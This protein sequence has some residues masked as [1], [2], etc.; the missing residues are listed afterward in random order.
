MR[1]AFDVS[2]LSHPPLGIGNYIRGSLGGLVEA[3]AGEHEIVAFAPTSIH[4]PARIRAAL[5]GIDVELRTWRLPFSHAV[6]TAWSAAGRPATERLLGAFD[7][8]HF[9]DWMFP[10][11]RSG[12]RATT[13]HDLVPLHHP[14]WTTSRTRSMHARKYENAARTCDVVF[15]NSAFTGRD[16]VETLGIDAERVHVARPA[17]KAVFRAD[18]DAADLGRPYVLTVATLEPRKNLQAL[19]EAHRLLESDLLLAIAGGEGW[20]E[21]PELDDPG[22][23]RLGFVTDA[24]L[25]RLYRGAAAAVY[26]SRFEGFGIPVIEAMACGC[27][28]V[29]S[30]HESLDEAAGDAAVRADPED[31]AAIAAAIGR[32]VGDRQRLAAAGLEHVQRSSWR[33]VGE[34]FLRGYEAAAR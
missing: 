4:G 20:G 7:V 21:Q 11:Q 34:I 13:I 24:E 12:V 27:P 16:V 28:V 23:R 9:S 8:L 31:P 3:A 26:P 32:A 1:I 14:E 2:P 15:V 6:R 17:P 19:V 18:G 25:A 33:V 5:D 22:I 29:V 10:P 30:S